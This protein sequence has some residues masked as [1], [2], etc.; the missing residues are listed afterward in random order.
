MTKSTYFSSMILSAMMLALSSTAYAQTTGNTAAA[1]SRSDV[2][3]ERDAFLK[4]HRYDETQRNWIPNTPSTSDTS[5][6]EVKSARDQYLST[7]RWDDANDNFVSITEK[8]RDMSLLS[9]E[10]VKMETMQ[11][12][13]THTWD[14]KAS[15]WVQRPMMD[16]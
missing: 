3:M 6:A 16:K 11:F 5:R 2:R 1:A 12:S 4:A 14:N 10:E 13:R 7:H 9:R 8:P 15:K